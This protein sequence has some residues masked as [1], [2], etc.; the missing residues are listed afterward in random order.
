M[1]GTVLKTPGASPPH[2]L[3]KSCDWGPLDFTDVATENQNVEVIQLKLPNAGKTAPG[4]NPGLSDSGPNVATIGQ[5]SLS[6]N[7]FSNHDEWVI[8]CAVESAASVACDL[9]HVFPYFQWPQKE[10]FF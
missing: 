8:T 7:L 2:F 10:A 1:P 9:S 5:L 6:E 4:S 3:Q